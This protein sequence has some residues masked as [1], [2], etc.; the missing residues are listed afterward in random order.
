M[1]GPMKLPRL[2]VESICGNES[3]HVTDSGEIWGKTVLFVDK[4]SRIPVGKRL[5][6]ELG[7]VCMT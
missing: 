2:F 6:E 7:T 3:L 5:G 4:M 1:T